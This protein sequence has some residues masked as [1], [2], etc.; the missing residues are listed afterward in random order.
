MKFSKNINKSVSVYS[1]IQ[2]K[3]KKKNLDS[4]DV[5]SVGCKASE[6]SDIKIYLDIFFFVIISLQVK[7]LG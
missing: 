6:N 5:F 3:K 7:K 4:Y 1:I 2:K